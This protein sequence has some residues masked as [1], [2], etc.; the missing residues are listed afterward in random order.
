MK[1]T[2]RMLIWLLFGILAVMI[3]IIE[4]DVRSG[5]IDIRDELEDIKY[6]ILK[7]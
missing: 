4:V 1:S 5:M 3:L 6:E 2:D 7:F